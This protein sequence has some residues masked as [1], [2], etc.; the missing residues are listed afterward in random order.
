VVLVM[1]FASLWTPSALASQAG[2]G[3]QWVTRDFGPA[4]DLSAGL[5]VSPDGATVFV[6]GSASS[7]FAVAARDSATGAERW[8]FRASD[9]RDLA[10]FLHAIAVSP[11]G[12]LVFATGDAEVTPETREYVTVA[13][14]AATGDP[15]WGAR[16]EVSAGDAAIP[17]AIA[18]SPDG[19]RVFV[20]G[21]RT[22]TDGG[23]DFWDYFT[24]AYDTATG[25]R[26]WSSTYG[27]PGVN[28]DVPVD[29]GVSPAGD[30]VYVTGTSVG[31]GTGRDF[32]TVA[33]DAATGEEQWV[34]RHGAEGDDYAAALVPGPGGGRLYVTGTLRTFIGDPDIGVVVYQAGSGAQLDAA[35]IDT[36]TADGASDLALSP[37]GGRVF[38]TGGVGYDFLTVALS[39]ATLRRVWTSTYSGPSGGLDSAVAVAVS[40]DGRGVYVTG[41][42]DNGRF[43]C[44]FEVAS[45]DMATVA[46]AAGTGSQRWSARYSGTNLQDSDLATAIV[47]SPDGGSVFVS[48][49]SDDACAPGDVATI[50]YAA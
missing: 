46:Y 37:R 24:V 1:A 22:G 17:N 33:Y 40:P 28:A 39:A 5:A 6:A 26:A 16:E 21:S 18:V 3:Q 35:A 15:V 50:S 25:A 32:A 31:D 44:G 14:D 9:P 20:T 23:S 49:L 12:G 27:G 29:I 41:T 4:S 47:A 43:T 36:G 10:D 13:I 8:T 11:D 30:L 42:S 34:A 2:G 38:V 7:Q 45:T 48:G 19:S